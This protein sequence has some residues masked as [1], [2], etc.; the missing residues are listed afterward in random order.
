MRHLLK[1]PIYI[2]MIPEL[3]FMPVCRNTLW[4]A[5]AIVRGFLP[6]AVRLDR[7]I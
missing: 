3:K 4:V 2:A 6:H 7:F 1:T 5:R